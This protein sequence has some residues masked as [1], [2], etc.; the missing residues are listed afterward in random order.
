MKSSRKA[1]HIKC[2]ASDCWNLLI[3]LTSFV[4]Q[5]LMHFG[6][7][8]AE[9]NVFLQLLEIIDLVTA[10]SRYRVEPPTLLAKIQA[11]VRIL[12]ESSVLKRQRPSSTGFFTCLNIWIACMT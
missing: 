5:V 2:S 12:R 3:P 11:F 9:C 4:Q 7:C 1:K 8:D 6:T 10:T